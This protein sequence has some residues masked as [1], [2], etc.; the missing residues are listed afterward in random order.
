VGG[1]SMMQNKKAQNLLICLELY[2]VFLI[3]LVAGFRDVFF[4]HIYTKIFFVIAV[5]VLFTG[6]I[7]Y[8]YLRTKG[9]ETMMVKNLKMAMWVGFGFAALMLI[10][11]FLLIFLNQQIPDIVMYLYGISLFLPIIPAS[12]IGRKR[13]KG[14]IPQISNKRKRV[15]LGFIALMILLLSVLSIITVLG[16]Y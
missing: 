2:S 15:V 6:I 10:V 5:V 8:I 11:I 7:E 12:F 14:E 13:R 1:R 4:S 9:D 3:I 16:L